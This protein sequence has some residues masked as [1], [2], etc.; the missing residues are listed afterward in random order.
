MYQST[1]NIFDP[2]NTTKLSQL[3][4][5]LTL[6]MKFKMSDNLYKFKDI[7]EILVSK[8]MNKLTFK[9]KYFAKVVEE[10]VTVQKMHFL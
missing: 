6:L 5:H 10:V 9:D 8:F 4:L 2:T 1:I 3:Y 7:I